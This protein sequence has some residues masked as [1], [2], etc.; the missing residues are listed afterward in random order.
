MENGKAGKE[1]IDKSTLI[2]SMANDKIVEIYSEE[3]WLKTKKIE[4]TEGKFQ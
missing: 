3:A 2:E 1:D 4:N